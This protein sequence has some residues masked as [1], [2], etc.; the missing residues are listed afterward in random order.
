MSWIIRSNFVEVT[1]IRV[2]L[3]LILHVPKE[4]MVHFLLNLQRGLY[5]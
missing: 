1:N 4:N 2:R 3:V 5:K